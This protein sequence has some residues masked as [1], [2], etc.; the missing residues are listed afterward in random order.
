M[1]GIL[2]DSAILKSIESGDIEIDP[3]VPEHV[4][5]ASY[6]VTLGRQVT[7]YR[8]WVDFNLHYQADVL[9]PR[10]GRDLHPVDKIMDVKEETEVTSFTIDPQVGWI[11]KPNIGYLMHTEERI[12]VSRRLEPVL[13]GKSSTGRLFMHIHVTAGYGDPGFNGQF[14]LE[15]LVRHPLRVYPGMRIG[16]VRFHTVEGEVLKDYSERDSAYKGP[17]ATGAIPSRAWRQFRKSTP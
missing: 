8:R 14:T 10:D 2:S 3:F 7:I 12:R 1:S 6:D 17:S 4:N 15:V 13:D 16:Q 5:A 9:G 11:L